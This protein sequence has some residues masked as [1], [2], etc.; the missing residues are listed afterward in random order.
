[1]NW[2]QVWCRK[3]EFENSLSLSHLS[4]LPKSFKCH[5]MHFNLSSHGSY[6]LDLLW[7]QRW[8]FSNMRFFT[9]SSSTSLLETILIESMTI[10]TSSILWAIRILMLSIGNWIYDLYMNCIKIILISTI[11]DVSSK[12]FTIINH[13]HISHDRLLWICITKSTI[14]IAF[15]S[16]KSIKFNTISLTWRVL[17]K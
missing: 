11:I 12:A 9:S 10:A 15:I 4:C 7:R 2:N 6:G 14:I 13:Y 1:M 17:E 8:Q 16:F 5:I 3:L